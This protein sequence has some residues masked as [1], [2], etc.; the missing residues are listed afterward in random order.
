MNIVLNV[1]EKPSVA[2]GITDLLSQGRKRTEFTNSQTNQVF[3]FVCPLEGQQ[4]KMYFTS[5]RGHLM[6]QE[7]DIKYRNWQRTPMQDILDAPIITSVSK[8]CKDIEKN[9]LHYSKM[10]DRLVLWLDCDR[11]GEAIAYEVIAVCRRVNAHIAVRRAIF[12]AVTKADIENACYRLRNPN[13]SLAEA[14]EARQEIDIRIGACMTRFMTV[15]YKNEIATEAKVLSYGPCQMPTL[16]FIVER[17]NKIESFVPE[18]FWSIQL[19]IEKDGQ[20]NVFLWDRGRL[21]DRLAALTLYEACLEN[22]LARVTHVNNRSTKRHPPLPLDTVEMHKDATRYLKVSSHES[23][24]LAE[25]L[26]NK[27]YIS[28]PRTETNVFPTSMNPRQ[29]VELFTNHPQFGDYAR[30]LLNAGNIVPRKGKKNDEAHPPIHPVKP[31]RREEADSERSWQLYE[32]ITRRF[33]ACCSPPAVGDESIVFIDISGEGFHSKGLVVRERN[34]LDVYPYSTWNGR[35]MPALTAGEEFMPQKLLMVEST[36]HAPG[37]LTERNLI[38]LMSK[39][40]IGTDA[41]M[42]EHIKKVQD[43]HYAKK[44]RNFTFL[45]TNLGKAIYKAFKEYRHASID[46]TKPNLRANMERDMAHI[47]SGQKQK[48]EVVA[49]Y[50]QQMKQ[51]FLNIRNNMDAFDNAMFALRNVRPDEA[52]LPNSAT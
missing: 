3:S 36:T 35:F 51:I 14:V 24:Q 13:R 16:G 29:F 27:G 30:K 1:A 17:F 38:E 34:W 48:Q 32:Y 28:Y 18:K 22:P 7:F 20:S 39:H 43:R 8:D 41:T 44:D 37:L 49:H 9:L 23:M 45:P 10:C 2:R 33:L 12:S 31:L 4:C 40:G 11:E 46:L 42:H 52:P 15:H 21:F 50:S 6:E 5:V 19:H 25:A 47:A 26:Y